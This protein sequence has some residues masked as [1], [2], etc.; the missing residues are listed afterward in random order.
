MHSIYRRQNQSCRGSGVWVTVGLGRAAAAVA[1][2]AVVVA[3][4]ME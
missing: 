1:M 2:D 3:A 4:F